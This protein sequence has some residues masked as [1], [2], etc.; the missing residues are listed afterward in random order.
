MYLKASQQRVSFDKH[1]RGA[2]FQTLKCKNFAISRNAN[3]TLLL[4]TLNFKTCTRLSKH[5][6]SVCLWSWKFCW[7]CKQLVMARYN[8]NRV[9]LWEQLNYPDIIFQ[10]WKQIT[11]WVYSNFPSVKIRQMAWPNYTWTTAF[12]TI[13]LK[14]IPKARCNKIQP[15]CPLKI[16]YKKP[17][18]P[19]STSGQL[20]M[21]QQLNHLSL[22]GS[23]SLQHPILR[24]FCK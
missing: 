21:I 3:H 6:V 11:A 2:G 1:W 5:D 19:K 16:K 17:K 9:I 20:T 15:K 12:S 13:N 7:C 10:M 4:D 22:S 18:K 8:V 23:R 24:C 14:N